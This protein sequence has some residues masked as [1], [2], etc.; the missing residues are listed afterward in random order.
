VDAD[1]CPRWCVPAYCAIDRPPL[2]GVV[3]A[4]HRSAPV[5]VGRVR[6][7]LVQGPGAD[8]PSVELRR[9]E[10]TMVLDLGEAQSL[11]PT[12]DD[13]LEAAGVGL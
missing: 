5:A 1:D 3:I 8:L 12:I 2:H 9:R 4:A 7:M 13:L 11:A 10:L 6:L